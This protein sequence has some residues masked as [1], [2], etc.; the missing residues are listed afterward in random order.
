MPK[1]A[2]RDTPICILRPCTSHSLDAQPGAN[3]L[4]SR[5]HHRH[6]S[7]SLKPH[8]RAT[9]P[10]RYKA[11]SL[12]PEREKK[13]QRGSSLA[14]ATCDAKWFQEIEAM[15]C[16]A[17][18]ASW[19]AVPEPWIGKKA[20]KTRRVVRSTRSTSTSR[21]DAE[22][23]LCRCVGQPR[24]WARRAGCAPGGLTQHRAGLTLGVRT[25]SGSLDAAESVSLFRAA[26]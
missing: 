20:T 15:S 11:C 8:Q 16:L 5:H 9:S 24:A 7:S 2:R 17:P 12:D 21:A 14:R 13:R 22:D 26:R 1:Q 3:Y 4:R 18:R 23:C 10:S 25:L 19:V 6:P